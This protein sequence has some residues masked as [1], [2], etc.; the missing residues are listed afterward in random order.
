MAEGLAN[1]PVT[2][3]VASVQVSAPWMTTVRYDMKADT[4]PAL[5]DRYAGAGALIGP[6]HVLTA[7]HLFDLNM[8]AAPEEPGDD[9]IPPPAPLA[10]RA[11]FV[12]VGADGI[13]TG[14]RYEIVEVHTEFSVMQAM[15]AGQPEQ[16]KDI[17]VLVLDR[18]VVDIEPIPL[19]TEPVAVND[20]VSVL[21]WPNGPWGHGELVQVNT[22]IVSADAAVFNYPCKDELSFAN[23]SGDDHIQR[24]FSGAPVFRF[25]S[26]DGRV[27]LVG[28]TSR[29]NPLDLGE[30][31]ESPG[32]F[33]DAAGAH[34]EFIEKCLAGVSA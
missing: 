15:G 8:P 23:V 27:E 12:R 22:C 6:Q 9:R 1:L 5:Q 24:G 31:L 19:A 11:H 32:T 25:T 13:D 7:G 3:A 17:A 2:P 18:P 10:E 26:H 28:V 29:G 34:R 33:A 16:M 20:R 14:D 21:G 4:N 30:G